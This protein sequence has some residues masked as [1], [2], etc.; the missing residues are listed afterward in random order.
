M[1]YLTSPEMWPSDSQSSDEPD[2][3]DEEFEQEGLR[4][5]LEEELVEPLEV[6]HS[7]LS[8]PTRDCNLSSVRWTSTVKLCH[9]LN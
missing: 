1:R 2:P 9:D 3:N 4:I 7:M 5:F 8:M 6:A